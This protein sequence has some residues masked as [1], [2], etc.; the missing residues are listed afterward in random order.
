MRY[1]TN[2][3]KEVQDEYAGIKNKYAE[4]EYIK[5][6]GE[7]RKQAIDTRREKRH[8]SFYINLKDV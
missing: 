1:R 5:K 6:D 2:D 3:S 4:K 8:N 7:K